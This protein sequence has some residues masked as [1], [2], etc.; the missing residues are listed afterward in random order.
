MP[1]RFV[2]PAAVRSRKDQVE[3]H[4]RRL[5]PIAEW[6]AGASAAELARLEQRLG[7]P[8]PPVLVALW[9]RVGLGHGLGGS[10]RGF[11]FGAWDEIVDAS[12]G[13][14]EATGLDGLVAFAEDGAGD[15][16]LVGADG[17]L[18]FWDHERPERVEVE[19]TFAEWI[20]ELVDAAL[21]AA[22]KRTRDPER[23]VQISIEGFDDEDAL[24]AILEGVGIERPAGFAWRELRTIPPNGPLSPTGTS[25]VAPM[26]Q[27]ARTIELSKAAWQARDP[28]YTRPTTHTLGLRG[29]PRTQEVEAIAAALEAALKRNGHVCSVYDYGVL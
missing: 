18:A 26:L 6:L 4:L 10:E 1:C 11:L 22:S 8:L 27:G 2:Y 29:D 25:W 17:A 21:S 16:F 28:R 9:G 13:V 15:V 3:D 24:F 23:R 14:A 12:L 5:E 20:A 7:A 19:G